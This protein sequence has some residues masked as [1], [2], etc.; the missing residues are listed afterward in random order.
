MSVDQRVFDDVVVWVGIVS[1]IIT[2][3]I[4]IIQLFLL[5]RGFCQRVVR[6]FEDVLRTEIGVVIVQA[7]DAY[8]SGRTVRQLD[9]QPDLD[10][11]LYGRYGSFR[12]GK[13]RPA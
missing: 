1:E 6:S 10:V 8:S 5:I 2:R 9:F 4:L 11:S 3:V 13:H 7:V 12:Y